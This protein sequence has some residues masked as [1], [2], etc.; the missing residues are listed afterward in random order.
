M[1]QVVRRWGMGTAEQPERHLAV[2]AAAGG[3][4]VEALIAVVVL[5]RI[6][7]PMGFLLVRLE[8]M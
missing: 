4:Q 1:G 2:A 8:S 5:G 7:V 6:A 3:D